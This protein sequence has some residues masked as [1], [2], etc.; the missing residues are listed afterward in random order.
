MEVTCKYM[1]QS[2]HIQHLQIHTALG[3]CF[4]QNTAC[5]SIL[6]VNHQIS[7]NNTDKRNKD[8]GSWKGYNHAMHYLAFPTSNKSQCCLKFLC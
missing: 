4:K 1:V 3:Q 7:H 6:E 2:H 8:C 5:N